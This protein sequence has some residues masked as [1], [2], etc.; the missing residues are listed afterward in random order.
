[1]CENR[2]TLQPQV[3]ATLEYELIDIE[4]S[5]DY[6]FT[7]DAPSPM[8]RDDAGEQSDSENKELRI[9]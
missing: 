2:D 7:G 6:D 1:M 3:T 8:V 9:E 5:L 4:W